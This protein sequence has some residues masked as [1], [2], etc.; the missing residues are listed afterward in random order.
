M[1]STGMG[2]TASEWLTRDVALYL[3]LNELSKFCRTNKA[4]KSLCDSDRFWADKLAIDYPEFI[5]ELPNGIVAGTAKSLYR[6]YY[7][8]LSSADPVNRFQSSNGTVINIPL[9]IVEMFMS[10]NSMVKDTDKI[11]Y[12]QTLPLFTNGIGNILVILAL[13]SYYFRML[14]RDGQIDPRMHRLNYLFTQ[15]TDAKVDRTTKISDYLAVLRRVVGGKIATPDPIYTSM[16]DIATSEFR[17]IAWGVT[18]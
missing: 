1:F 13:M 9:N 5:K 7:L 11:D 12:R 10:F 16:F 17:R 18:R 3:P 4:I 14:K 6:A 2:K 15:Y 8:Q